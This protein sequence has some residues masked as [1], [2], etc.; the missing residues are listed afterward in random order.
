MSQIPTFFFLTAKYMKDLFYLIHSNKILNELCE[1]YRYYVNIHVQTRNV[2]YDKLKKPTIQMGPNG[3][4]ISNLFNFV[5]F[6]KLLRYAGSQRI[7]VDEQLDVYHD[8][9]KMVIDIFNKTLKDDLKIL[10]FIEIVDNYPILS[11]QLTGKMKIDQPVVDRIKKLSV[12]ARFMKYTERKALNLIGFFKND[13]T[14]GIDDCECEDFDCDCCSATY[15]IADSDRITLDHRMIVKK[16]W[17]LHIKT[18]GIVDRLRRRIICLV[19]RY[20]MLEV[21]IPDVINFDYGLPSV[22]R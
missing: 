16:L 13:I 6:S 11:G 2:V 20:P 21:K 17:S 8:N 18:S 19:N 22:Y 10:R 15:E 12:W 1:K 7:D 9:P 14:S 5:E 4:Y 3:P